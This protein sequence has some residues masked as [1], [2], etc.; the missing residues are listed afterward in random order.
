MSGFEATKRQKKLEKQRRDSD[1]LKSGSR[2]IKGIDYRIK[3]ANFFRECFDFFYCVFVKKKKKKSR[4]GVTLQLI[5]FCQAFYKRVNYLGQLS[6]LWSLKLK[7]NDD[8]FIHLKTLKAL[9]H[10]LNQFSRLLTGFSSSVGKEM[11]SDDESVFTD[12]VSVISNVS[13]D[14]Y[15]RDEGGNAMTAEAAADDEDLTQDELF[16]EKL[17]DTIELA[18]QKSAA[19]R[20]NALQ[21][22]CTAFSKKFVPDFVENRRMTIIDIVE[23][24]L[25][26]GKASEQVAAANLAVALCIQLRGEADDLYKSTKP[27]L[28]AVMAD[29]SAAI[30]ARVACAQALGDLCFFAAQAILEVKSV[31]EV[32]ENMFQ[33]CKDDLSALCTA[34]VSAWTL[35]ST[36][37]PYSSVE[38]MLVKLGPLFSKLLDSPDVELRIATGEAIAVLYEYVASDEDEENEEVEEAV[39]E[40]VPKLQSLS[41]DCHKY[42]SKKDRKEQKS[43]FRDILRTV[44]EGDDYYERV[45][46]NSREK[47]EI[48]SWAHKKQYQA[49]CKVIIN[50]FLVCNK[51]SRFDFADELKIGDV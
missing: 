6:W 13:D 23:K 38:A 9:R 5:L 32:M 46:I 39:A 19:G 29:R 20:V 22:I 30:P 16:E 10:I 7:A 37:M 34:T 50:Y 1:R 42:R 35:L 4:N 24:S 31:M 44:N 8:F 43:S 11:A 2:P 47:L 36:V 49:I 33:T 18:T 26:K 48:E 27:I 15:M 40:L 12:N 17:R 28:M 41:T 25:K 21:A 3:A 14:S 51:K 45:N